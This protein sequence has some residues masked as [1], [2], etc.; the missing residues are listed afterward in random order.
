V[1]SELDIDRAPIF[2]FEND[3]NLAKRKNKFE[4]EI[5]AKLYME[6]KERWAHQTQVPMG[7]LI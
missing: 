4:Y 6:T 1:I 7:H 2:A 3:A 5:N